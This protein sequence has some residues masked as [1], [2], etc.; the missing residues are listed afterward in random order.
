MHAASLGKR[1][2]GTHAEREKDGERQ[3]C[4]GRQGKRQRM[5]RE[6]VHGHRNDI[7]TCI[8]EWKRTFVHVFQ[9]W[10]RARRPDAVCGG[11]TQI[12]CVGLVEHRPLC[13]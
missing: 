11:E 7:R 8:L 10:I 1:E 6:T 9:S 4:I 5:E 13:L 3:R 2:S 12:I